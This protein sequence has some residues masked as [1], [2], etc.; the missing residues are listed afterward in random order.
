MKDKYK[1]IRKEQN[2]IQPIQGSV[3]GIQGGNRMCGSE[4]IIEWSEEIIAAGAS[5]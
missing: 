5:R 1:T 2:M 4:N 3:Q